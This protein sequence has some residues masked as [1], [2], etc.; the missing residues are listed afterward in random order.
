MGGIWQFFNSILAHILEFFSGIISNIRSSP[1][2]KSC[3]LEVFKAAVT[4]L[5]GYTS[6]K[7][8]QRYKNKKDNNL[9]YIQFLKLEKELKLNTQVLSFNLIE[10][11]DLV[12]LEI[13]FTSGIPGLDLLHLYSS[14]NQL[15][16]YREQHGEDFRYTITPQQLIYEIE[17][18]LAYL[19][20]DYHLNIEQIEDYKDRINYYNNKNIFVDLSELESMIN[21]FVNMEFELKEPIKFLYDNLVAFNSRPDSEKINIQNRFCEYL[22]ESENTFKSSIHDFD[23]FI[24]LKTKLNKNGKP[25]KSNVQFSA[26]DRIDVDLLAAYDAE[27]FIALEEVYE[28]LKGLDILVNN[29]DSLVEANK[30]VAYE[31]FPMLNQSSKHL[32]GIL[33]KTNKLFKSI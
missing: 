2:T 24:S 8:Y 23:R 13:K 7:I 4:L 31:L 16:I 9:V 27:L 10:H 5:F 30:I 32:R 18:E 19:Q 25:V 17:S 33:V 12:S 6:F 3:I 28:R 1:F 20:E 29:K 26:W 11:K 22:L 21:P 14:I 15:Y